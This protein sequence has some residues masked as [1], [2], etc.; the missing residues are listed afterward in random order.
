MP[1]TYLIPPTSHQ[2]THWEEGDVASSPSAAAL[3]LSAASDE[4]DGQEFIRDSSQSIRPRTADTK[5]LHLLREHG[6]KASSVDYRGNLP[7]Y[8]EAREGKRDQVESLIHYDKNIN[9]SGQLNFTPLNPRHHFRRLESPF[10]LQT[11]EFQSLCCC[12]QLS[13]NSSL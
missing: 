5:I 7:I 9:P 1:C 4:G 2:K 6:T 10:Q 8:V 12:K 13:I 3:H 11:R